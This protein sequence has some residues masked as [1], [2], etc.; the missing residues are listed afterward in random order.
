MRSCSRYGAKVDQK[1]CDVTTGTISEVDQ[2][3][4]AADPTVSDSQCANRVKQAGVLITYGKIVRPH[5]TPA[6]SASATSPGDV[7]D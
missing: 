5:P 4:P 7:D 3:V 1:S 2:I 6:L